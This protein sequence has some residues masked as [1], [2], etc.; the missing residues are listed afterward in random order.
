MHL[1][2]V[3]QNGVEVGKIRFRGIGK[4]EAPASERR[5]YQC[6]PKNSVPKDIVRKIADR[7][8]FGVAAGNEGDYVWHT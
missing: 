8:A 6:S 1:V 7:L 3:I 2:D 5:R 4:P